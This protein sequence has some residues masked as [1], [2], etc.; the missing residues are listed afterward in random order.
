MN[1]RLPMPEGYPLSQDFVDTVRRTVDTQGF[2]VLKDVIS[3]E[4]IATANEALDSVDVPLCGDLRPLI[5][6]HPAFLNFLDH[7]NLLPYLLALV[8]GNLQLTFSTATIVPPDAGPMCWHED[9]PR[10]CTYPA[11]G[12]RRAQIFVRMGIFLEDLSE[13]DR[14][15][16]VLVPGSHQVLFHKGGGTEGMDAMPNLTTLYASAGS[17]VIFHQALWHRTAP[18]LM[19]HPRR[20]LYFGF[21]PSWHRTID[22]L[23]PPDTLLEWVDEA[24]PERRA[25]LR[26]LV[27]CVPEQGVNGFFFNDE[28]E[29][30]GLR[31]VPLKHPASGA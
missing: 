13:P 28:Y 7:P 15:N 20:V 27:G 2:I 31:L 3:A 30:P 18:N 26:Q 12:D 19:D 25:L 6:N 17:V 23:T 22:Y 21:T 24:P 4:E 1:P 10:P 9:G 8:G 11:V 5:T 14:G 29:F 16:L